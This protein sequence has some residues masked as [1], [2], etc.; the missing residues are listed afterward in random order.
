MG[1]F[2]EKCLQHEPSQDN[3]EA[4]RVSF[5]KQMSTSQQPLVDPVTL[6]RPVH[7]YG[8]QSAAEGVFGSQCGSPMRSQG[9][10]T[11]SNTSSPGKG[12]DG[13]GSTKSGWFSNNSGAVQNEDIGKSRQETLQSK[14]ERSKFN[15][16]NKSKKTKYHKPMENNAPVRNS[17]RKDRS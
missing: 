8:S 3:P 16:F 9:P 17:R 11:W 10:P 4:N 13:T 7:E 5:R 6:D 14:G 15:L 12:E 2:C 1:S